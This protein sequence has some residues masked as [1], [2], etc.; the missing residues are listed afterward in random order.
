MKE[1]ERQE[2]ERQERRKEETKQGGRKEGRKEDGWKKK[3]VG[4]LG[5]QKLE[6]VMEGRHETFKSTTDLSAVYNIK[7]L[8]NHILTRRL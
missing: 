3:E 4:K 7:A 1:G 5:S 8:N 2:G 6:V